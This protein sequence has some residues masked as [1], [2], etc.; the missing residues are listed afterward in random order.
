MVVSSSIARPLEGVVLTTS[1]LNTDKKMEIHAAIEALGG[2]YSIHMTQGTT[3]LA[4]V[5][6]TSEKY[7]ASV[8]MGDIL[9]V[10]PNWPLECLKA[11]SRL[12]EIRF[13]VLPFSGIRASVTG[14]PPKRRAE[15]VALLQEHGGE[16]GGMLVKGATHLIAEAPRGPKY[17]TAI[18]WGDCLVVQGKWVDKCVEVGKRVM[19]DE[20]FFPSSLQQ[21][22]VVLSREGRGVND[23][24]FSLVKDPKHGGSAV[25]LMT[26]KLKGAEAALEQGKEALTDT[27]QLVTAA[28]LRNTIDTLHE[29]NALAE[30]RI[31]FLGWPAE[32]TKLLCWVALLG[33]GTRHSYLNELITH[34]V[35]G[36]RNSVDPR[37]LTAIP[38]HPNQPALVGYRWL[39]N[40]VREKRKLDAALFPAP[41][42]VE[43]RN[44]L[45][46]GSSK[47]NMDNNSSKSN[48]RRWPSGIMRDEGNIQPSVMSGTLVVIHGTGLSA[49]DSAALG[50][51]VENCGG[52]VLSPVAFSESNSNNNSIQSS[53]LL[54]PFFNSGDE[55]KKDI[56]GGS[57]INNGGRGG[58]GTCYIVWAHGC[59]NAPSHHPE[60]MS[61]DMLRRL[62]SADR[63]VEHVSV[64]WLRAVLSVG[65]ILPLSDCRWFKPISSPPR[66]VPDVC[67]RF[68]I[69]LSNFTWGEKVGLHWVAREIGLKMTHNLTQSNTHLICGG[70]TGPKYHAARRWGLQI[71]SVS[72]LH[73]CALNG[74]TAGSE[75]HHELEKDMCS[76]NDEEVNVK[77][78]H[79]LSNCNDNDEAGDENV[80]PKDDEGM[81]VK[82]GGGL[83]E[84]QS[85][86]AVTENMPGDSGEEENEPEPFAPTQYTQP[87]GGVLET[88]L[89]H[90]LVYPGGGAGGANG[91]GKKRHRANVFA[92]TAI[93]GS[94]QPDRILRSELELKVNAFRDGTMG[95]GGSSGDDVDQDVG[96]GLVGLSQVQESQVVDYGSSSIP[97]MSRRRSR[98]WSTSSGNRWVND[99]GRDSW[100]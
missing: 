63:N 82:L 85:S 24:G 46:S 38:I 15:I 49:E 8:S 13:P 68:S 6:T 77:T 87:G 29:S 58:G 34:V 11:R 74:Y 57:G 81:K 96:H 45:Q 32:E 65:V 40:S 18:E 33:H 12:P 54:P 69:C 92:M 83:L 2:Q 90:D 50:R 16:Y 61:D 98:R 1:N 42:V 66:R 48:I 80:E 30:C 44:Y 47:K 53:V 89:L 60:G 3:H 23:D 55:K 22:G 25:S 19:E 93:D 37:F 20:F 52:N 94:G 76:Q 86:E 28:E 35:L 100:D 14:F 39:V 84:S 67:A 36:D 70:P 10:T 91:G 72:W 5:T 4:T 64:T 75:K 17:E 97:P 79:H 99:H 88:T 27:Q 59:N 62:Y 73:E 41:Q 71:V 56:N 9:I 51:S 26:T 78:M 43:N 95:G 31:L 7:R 21:P